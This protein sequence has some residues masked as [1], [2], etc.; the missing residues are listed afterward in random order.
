MVHV[1]H[2]CDTASIGHDNAFKCCNA[3]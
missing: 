3:R 1:S 2:I